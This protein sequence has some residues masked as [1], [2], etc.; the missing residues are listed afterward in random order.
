MISHRTRFLFWFS[1][2]P[3]LAQVASLLKILG[4]KQLNTHT[5]THSVGLLWTSDQPVA[6]AATYTTH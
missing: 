1:N 4:H 6:E 5:H 2:S 3:D